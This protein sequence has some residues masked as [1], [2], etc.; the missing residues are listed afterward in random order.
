MSALTIR[1]MLIRLALALSLLVPVPAF[2]DEFDAIREFIRARMV[3]TQVPSITVAI[4]RDGKI[5]WEE[6]F[7][8]AD[9][10]KRIPANEHTMYS[11]AS[12]TKPFTATALMTLV[13]KKVIDL[14]R[15]VNQYLADAKVRARIGSAD[16]ATIR[17]VANHTSGLPVQGY[18]S[19][20]E[21]WRPPS[22][23][24]TILRYGNLV[25]IPGEK[26]EYTN[27]G[28]GILG[29]VIARMS[30]QSYEDYMRDSVF[31][32]LGLTHTSVGIEP[33]LEQFA[34]VRYDGGVPISFSPPPHRA[35][36]GIYS[37][38]H[39]LIRFA[40]FHLK[41]HL[42]DQVPI[43]SDASIDEMQ[44]PTV[45]TQQCDTCGY[46][47][48]WLLNEGSGYPTVN[49][50][51]LLPGASGILRLVP[52]EK[53]AMVV[54]DNSRDPGLPREIINK[55]LA[56]LLP[57]YKAAP[58]SPRSQPVPFQPPSSLVGACTGTLSTY[59]TEIPLTLN[60]L[61]SGEV[62]ARL[63]DGFNLPTLLDGIAWDNDTLSGVM[64]ADFET[65]D[66]GRGS[67]H[68]NVSLKLRGNLLN[69]AI[70]AVGPSGSGRYGMAPT[71]AH[72]VELKRNDVDQAKR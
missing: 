11:I 59:K 42:P 29:H 62:H 50:D 37:S 52:S 72:W 65:D 17:R 43:L 44:K 57:K 55:A 5:V 8:W 56:T 12:I 46:G 33:G 21:S 38:A 34:A 23:D 54:L 16:D 64:L 53:I 22:M 30:G 3:E 71:L 18:F 31:L 27:L 60:V 32:K 20:N 24:E 70:I 68:L 47:V 66:A 7:G 36:A 40:M 41:A 10:D 6:G 15:S 49:H 58:P 13:E 14:D 4:A 48:G 63:T 2:A 26:W 35:A 45:R 39:D 19:S 1:R 9:R 25:T 51:G 61:A 67:Y 28:Y 69:G